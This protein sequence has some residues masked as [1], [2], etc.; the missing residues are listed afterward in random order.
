ML[1]EVA[2]GLPHNYS[3]DIFYVFFASQFV[4]IFSSLL[5]NLILL[6]I[7][8]FLI[9]KFG[10]IVLPFITARLFGSN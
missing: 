10:G 8:G 4:S 2:K 7:P 6:V 5:G 3:L 9:Y 1:D